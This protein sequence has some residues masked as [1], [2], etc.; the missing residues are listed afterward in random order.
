[1]IKF[2]IELESQ[3]FAFMYMFVLFVFEIMRC[4]IGCTGLIV[5]V[6]VEALRDLEAV[7]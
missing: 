1:M 5:E 4:V 2:Q 7:K 3:E 6:E